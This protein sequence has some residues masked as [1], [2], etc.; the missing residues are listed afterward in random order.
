MV[1]KQK[2]F[3]EFGIPDPMSRFDEDSSSSS[4]Y[5]QCDRCGRRGPV[6]KLFDQQLCKRCRTRNPQ[7]SV[8]GYL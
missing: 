3:I 4:S 6:K 1:I 5:G 8:E 2:K 7:K